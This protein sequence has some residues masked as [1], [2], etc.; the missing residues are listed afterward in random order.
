VTARTNPAMAIKMSKVMRLM[1]IL[2][3]EVFLSGY[4]AA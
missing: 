1:A 3:G 4:P 2:L